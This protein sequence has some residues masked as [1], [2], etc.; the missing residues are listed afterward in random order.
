MADFTSLK[1]AA[2]SISDDDLLTLEDVL[3]SNDINVVVHEVPEWV[4]TKGKP[5]KL[6][7]KQFSNDDLMKYGELIEGKASR[8]ANL[9][10]VMMSAVKKDGTP[11]F[12]QQN[13]RELQK[14]SAPVFNR[15][16]KAALELNDVKPG[17]VA[18]AKND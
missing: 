4:T 6:L 12:T 1:D 13:L 5:G 14:K 15:I 10:L 17:E 9:M 11:F 18:R 3:S 2:A 7:L 8:Q 16:A